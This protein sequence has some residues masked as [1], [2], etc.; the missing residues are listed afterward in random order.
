QPRKPP[1][2]RS[3]AGLR[4]EVPREL[5]DLVEKALAAEPQTRLASATA[6]RDGLEAALNRP[7]RRFSRRGLA[8]LT[9]VAAAIVAAVFFWSRGSRPAVDDDRIAVAPFEVLQGENTLWREGFV[10]LLSSNLDGAGPLR[11]VPPS[12]VMRSWD[13]HTDVES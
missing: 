3:L 7:T 8:V 10:D 1:T 6:L 13:G 9:L 11:T 5:S 2:P 12:V 4:P